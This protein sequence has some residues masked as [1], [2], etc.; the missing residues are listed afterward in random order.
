ME[1]TLVAETETVRFGC[2]SNCVFERVGNPGSRFC[3]KEGDL[4]VVCEDTEN[5]AGAGGK[6]G[7]QYT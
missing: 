2:K 7:R 1:Y 3:F 4:K 5:G 6:L